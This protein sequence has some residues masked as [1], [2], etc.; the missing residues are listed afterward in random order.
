MPH[1]PYFTATTACAAPFGPRLPAVLWGLLLSLLGLLIA[2]TA[3]A[4]TPLPWLL[5]RANVVAVPTGAGADWSQAREVALPH[6]WDASWPGP[7]GL[8]VYR[9]HFIAPPA[10]G[11][12][13]L[14]LSVERACNTL[15]VSL[16][17]LPVHEGGQVEEPVS[18]QCQQRH[19]VVIPGALIL[20]LIHI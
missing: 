3:Q 18:R 4:D 8:A 16:N 9:L 11:T 7:S 12:E 6:D 15:W 5:D 1:L 19:L 2:G 20:S 13:L 17:G 10:A 14:A